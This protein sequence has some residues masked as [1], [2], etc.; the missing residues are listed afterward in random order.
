MKKHLFF[1]WLAAVLYLL[2]SC[3]KEEAVIP[4]GPPVLPVA[5]DALRIDPH[6][7]HLTA[8]DAAQ[9]SQLFMR[10]E[11]PSPATRAAF[12]SK[13][14]ENTFPIRSADGAVAAYAVNYRE[15]GFGIVSATKKFAPI[16]AFSESGHLTPE[17]LEGNGIAF[18][19]SCMTADIVRA[20]ASL[21]E[22]SPEYADARALWRDYERSEYAS[23]SA[24]ANYPRD[25]YYWS[26]QLRSEFMNKSWICRNDVSGFKSAVSAYGTSVGSDLDARVAEKERLLKIAYAGADVPSAFVW[27]EGKS[28]ESETKIMPIVGTYWH[29]RYPY[30]KENEPA[31]APDKQRYPAGCVTIAVSQIMNYHRHPATVSGVPIDWTLT[32]EKFA[33]TEN[34]EIPKLIRLVNIGV[35]TENGPFGSSSN[36]VYARDFLRQNGYAVTQYA[37]D[38]ASVVESEIR[39][40]RPVYMRGVQPEA[41]AG[42]AWICDGF[43]SC[44]NHYAI[45]SYTI[46]QTQKE[47][48]TTTPYNRE[49]ARMRSMQGNIFYHMNWGWKESYV[50]ETDPSTLHRNSVGW[51][52]A[53]SE[54]NENSGMQ[55][56]KIIPEK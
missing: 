44:V 7:T 35:K 45:D 52:R 13:K 26:L 47:N 31:D 49:L 55:I 48:F 51:Y 20:E 32:Q 15:G 22:D 23:A 12:E 53:F 40:N 16:L 56:L 36:I 2:S 29:Q 30:N 50:D 3:A 46:S 21:A 19:T 8:D 38:F 43:Y 11:G 27:G 4:D 5:E 9:V 42:H 54:V 39:A 14:I 6:A 41:S 25:A 18:W 10:R 34:P 1:G 33:S 17:A 24:A 37:S 28:G